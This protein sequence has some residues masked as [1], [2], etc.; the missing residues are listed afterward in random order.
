[1]GTLDVVNLNFGLV[2]TAGISGRVFNDNGIGSGIANDGVQNG[3]EMGISGVTIKL[4]DA[5][6]VTTY[7]TTVTDNSGDYSLVVPTTLAAGTVLK[8]VESNLSGYISTGAQVGNTSGTYAIA[9]DTTSFTLVANSVYSSVNFADV[10]N[11]T[12]TPNSAQSSLPGTAVFYPH[13]FTAGT[14]G[15]VTITSSN[16]ST[17]ATVGWNTLIYQ[18]ANCNGVIDTAEA[19]AIVSTSITVI[20]GQTICIVVKENIPANAPYNAQDQ[21]TVNAQFTYANAPSLAVALLV[22]QDLTTIGNTTGTG[23]V[24]Q[25]SVRNITSG[26]PLNTSNQGK[27]NDDLEYV[28][29]YTNS[30][31]GVLTNVVIND[32]TPA[33]T[34]F[35][36]ATCGAPISCT[37]LPVPATGAA[38]AIQWALS[39]PVPAGG[40]GTVNF[41]VRIQ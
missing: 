15:T 7:A 13:T 21:I 25:K 14:A 23:L 24:L 2:L 36:S 22:R 27:S 18:D 38:G 1:V 37:I 30:S 16:I 31:P 34:V 6:G 10:S 29:S 39:A 17:P 5:T 28:I 26:T 9:S 32:T 3:G 20:A 19:S 8:V 4:T 35:Q 11:N 41:T 33:F 12:F 40:V